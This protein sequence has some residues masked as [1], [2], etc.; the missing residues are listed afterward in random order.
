MYDQ[1]KSRRREFLPESTGVHLAV[2]MK[3]GDRSPDSFPRKKRRRKPGETGM[4]RDAEDILF[5][6]DSKKKNCCP[7]SFAKRVVPVQE[8]QP[9]ISLLV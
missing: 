8:N 9:E 6:H 2:E 5:I 1:S 3:P 7:T 4:R